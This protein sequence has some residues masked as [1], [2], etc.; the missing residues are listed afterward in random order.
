M[1]SYQ[2]IS[3]AVKWIYDQ[4]HCFLIFLAMTF[5]KEECCMAIF[6]TNLCCIGSAWCTSLCRKWDGCQGKHNL[7]HTFLCMEASAHGKCECIW[8]FRSI[9]PK[10]V[11]RDISLKVK[12]ENHTISGYTHN[13][14]RIHGCIW[15]TF[16]FNLWGRILYYITA[17]RRTICI[18]NIY[19]CI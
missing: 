14:I 13:T 12:I 15:I 18:N 8:D 3:T 9:Y 5:D 19:C 4:M 6:L 10:L 2:N 7:L 1:I 17:T 16:V 11:H